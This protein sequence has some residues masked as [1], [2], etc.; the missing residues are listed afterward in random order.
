MDETIRV[1]GIENSD[2]YNT[3]VLEVYQGNINQRLT[4]DRYYIGTIFNIPNPCTVRPFLSYM[5]FTCDVHITGRNITSMDNVRVPVNAVQNYCQN[6]QLV[7]QMGRQALPVNRNATT[8]T[9]AGA[10]EQPIPQPGTSY[11]PHHM[12]AN[13]NPLQPARD[14]ST[15]H[16]LTPPVPSARASDDD[17]TFMLQDL[18]DSDNDFQDDE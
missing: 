6:S 8:P 5:P 16:G 11:D 17:D 18:Y 12:T 10:S 2:R 15:F 3:L 13:I 14:P 4:I 1:V 9:G 7:P